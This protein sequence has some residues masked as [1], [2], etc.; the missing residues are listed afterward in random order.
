MIGNMEVLLVKL[1]CCLLLSIGMHDV[2]LNY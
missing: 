2:E 1:C